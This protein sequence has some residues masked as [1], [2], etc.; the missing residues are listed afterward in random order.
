M[1]ELDANAVLEAAAS[2]PARPNPLES[3]IEDQRNQPPPAPES[4]GVDYRARI[5]ALAL[6][7]D[8]GF[9]Y[10]TDLQAATAQ[11]G[12]IIRTMGEKSLQNEAAERQRQAEV[13]EIITELTRTRSMQPDDDGVAYATSAAANAL[14]ETTRE[15]QE[16][17]LEQA[18]LDRVEELAAAGDDTQARVVANQIEHGSTLEFMRDNEIKRMIIA[19]NV[20]KLEREQ[21][22]Q[23]WLMNVADFVARMIPAN[24]PVSR[25]GNVQLPDVMR[26]WYDGL[27]SGERMQSEVASLYSLPVNEFSR[28]VE[29]EL[30]PNIR[31]NSTLMG[32]YDRTEALE[33]MRNFQTTPGVLETNIGDALDNFGWIGPTEIAR[34]VRIPSMLGRFGAR[35]AATSAVAEAF[36]RTIAQGSAQATKITGITTE[37]I[38]DASLVSAVNSGRGPL[39]VSIAVDVERIRTK[40]AEAMRALLGDG[41]PSTRL[42]TPE[43]DAAIQA[44]ENRI[45]TQFGESIRDVVPVSERMATG[46]QVHYVEFVLGK[47]SGGL[48]ASEAQALKR[49]RALGL[50]DG[51]FQVVPDESGGFG[52]RVRRAVDERGFHVLEFNQG[53]SNPWYKRMLGGQLASDDALQGITHIASDK[54]GLIVSNVIKP[55]QRIF[56]ALRGS[57]R[58]NVEAVLAKQRKEGVWYTN[59]FTQSLWNEAFGRP[60]NQREF[61]ALTTARYVNDIEWTLRNDALYT[62]MATSGHRQVSFTAGVNAFDAPGIV[63]ELPETLGVRV[64]DLTTQTHILNVTEETLA[65]LRAEGYQYIRLKGGGQALDDG[66]TISAFVGKPGSF[67]DAELSRIQMAY[68]S[69]GHTMYDPNHVTH[70]ARQAVSSLQADTGKV[71]MLNPRT[72]IGGTKAEV[73]FWT[74][75]MEEARQLYLR[76][77]GVTADVLDDLF[78]GHPGLPT[79]DDFIKGMDGYVHEDGRWRVDYQKDMPFEVNADRQMPTAYDALDSQA[80]AF[81]DF[82]EGGLNGWRAQSGRMYYSHKG[83]DLLNY[84]GEDAMILDAYQT[85]NRSLM[86]A[87]Q[88]SSFGD[89]KIEAVNRWMKSFSKM[90]KYDAHTSPIRQFLEATP[91]PNQDLRMLNIAESNRDNIKRTLSWKSEVDRAA[92]QE[93]R[94]FLDWLYGN[95]PTSFQHRAAGKALEFWNNQDPV[96]ALRSLASNLKLGFFNP[97]QFLLQ[98]S[99]SVAAFTMSPKYAAKGMSTYWF[100]RLYTANSA[101]DYKALIKLG[102]FADEAEAKAYLESWRTSGFAEVNQHALS[103]YYGPN[104]A[105]SQT[106]NALQDFNERGLFFFNEAERWNRVTAHRIAWGEAIDQFGQRAIGTPE[107]ERFLARR[108]HDYSFHMGAASR[109]WWQTGVLSIPTQFWGYS[110]RMTE[111]MFGR[112]FASGRT[113]ISLNRL[114][115]SQRAKLIAGQLLFFGTSGTGITMALQ[116]LGQVFASEAPNT[117]P[118]APPKLERGLLD[119]IIYYMTDGLTDEPGGL[120]ISAGKRY[121][122]GGMMVDIVREFFGIS[123]YGPTSPADFLGGASTGILGPVVGSFKDLVWYIGMESGSDANPMSEAALQRLMNNISTVGNAHKA[124]ILLQYQT[125]MTR[126][127]STSVTNLPKWDAL[128][129]ALGF[130]PGEVDQLSAMADYQRRKG[131]IIKEASKVVRNYRTRMLNEPDNIAEIGEEM[132]AYIRLLPDDIRAKVQKHA[133]DNTDASFFES[134]AERIERD[135]NEAELRQD[136]E[137]RENGESN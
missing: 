15:R 57:E 72:F 103:D 108:R 73:Q 51:D 100:T 26:R 56:R 70:F 6:T 61:E 58:A 94:R 84:L 85:I 130:A 114:M 112:T 30:I 106:G 39:N 128:A 79:G 75:R 22:A 109:A 65:R 92:D 101:I 131:E 28:Y 66:T 69:G 40:G 52:L 2:G 81:V 45:R 93:G 12:E 122:V 134:L 115:R 125:Y 8:S 35:K 77:E 54:K 19:R 120:D 83:T 13:R 16:A 129:V 76:P 89:L 55:A 43:M 1:D 135:R 38:V 119:T 118:A 23:G 132:N 95:D 49:G 99:T 10:L 121:G 9:D 90:Y 62:E 67:Q 37:E 86:N 104:A 36:E 7:P 3:I 21:E 29:E 20:L 31:E 126:G 4:T 87:A 48:Y 50:A 44:T 71:V 82:E 46:S 33:L 74:S 91:H 98:V 78:A 53:A 42:T 123:Q 110:A 88:L 68:R 5:A 137:E 14:A 124:M 18:A 111:A 32:F 136:L 59:E 60:M 105:M 41:P 117:D 24:Y 63:S 80:L 107:F 17:A 47:P 34:A 64:F 102:G 27:F 97:G 127:G 96:G 25:G 133:H 113:D 116:Q 11:Y